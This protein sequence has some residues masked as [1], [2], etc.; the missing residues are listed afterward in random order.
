MIGKVIQRMQTSQADLFKVLGVET[1][2][3]IIQLLKEKGPLGV[4]EMS[5]ALGLTASAVSQHLRVLKHAGL[6]RNE[7]RG[8]W[9]PYR[10]DPIAMERCRRLLTEVCRCGC[11]GKL[12]VER[13]DPKSRKEMLDYLREYQKG[14]KRELERVESRLREL[15]KAG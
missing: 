12:G 11:K 15:E 4:N 14:L 2:I 6:V 13:K 5:E 9:V 1:R 7:R 3:R 10:V 8:Y